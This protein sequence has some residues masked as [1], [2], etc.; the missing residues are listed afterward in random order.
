MNNQR[1]FVYARHLR[2]GV[3]LLLWLLT[4]L[5]AM[6]SGKPAH[7]Q[8]G[9]ICRDEGNITICGD[10]FKDFTFDLGIDGYQ[11]IGNV[12]LGM[13]GKPPVVR[14]SDATGLPAGHKYKRATFEHV[15]DPQKS[16]YSRSN[17]LIG[18]ILF[19]NDPKQRAP[20]GSNGLTVNGNVFAGAF[21]VNTAGEIRSLTADVPAYPA[22]AKNR[23]ALLFNQFYLDHLA[24]RAM[25]AED[26]TVEDRSLF[27]AFYSLDSREFFVFIEIPKLRLFEN[28]ENPALPVEMRIDMDEKGNYAGSATGFKMRMAG[29]TGEAKGIVV[30]PG[31]F[32]ASTLEFSRTDNPSLPNLDPTNPNLVFRLESLKYKDG[33]F[34]VG[35]VVGI[36]DWQLGSAMRLT[37]QSVGLF[38]DNVLKTTSIVISSTLTFPARSVATDGGQ[39]P[40][41]LELGAKQIGGQLITFGKGVLRNANRPALSFGAFSLG[42][43]AATGFVL[44]PQRN[45]Y[46]IEAEQVALTWKGNLGGQTGVETSFK[47]GVNS[48]RALVFSLS[49][50]TIAMPQ[51]RSGALSTQ[52]TGTVN[53]VNDTVTFVLR[54]TARLFLPGNSAVA[55]TAELTIKS[56]KEVCF[57]SCGPTY[58]M[59]LSGFELKVA[60]FALGLKD[61]RGTDDGGFAADVVTLKVPTGI[62][63]FGGQINGFKVT[64]TGD[65]SITGGS[66]ELP[67]LQIGKLSFVGVKG[68]FVKTT[69]GGYEFRGAGVMPLPGLDPSG[70][71]AGK[72]ITVD[73]IV[74]TAPTGDF[75][76]MGVKVLFSTG[77]P[78]IPIGTTGMELLSIS[79]TFDLNAGTVKI[80]V[81]LRAGTSAR[82]GPLPV[83]TINAKADLQ[84]NPFMFTANGELSLLIFK[85]ANAS[86][87]IGHQQ[88]FNGGPG[89]NVSFTINAVIVHGNTFLRVGEVQLSNGSKTTR[90][91]AESRWALG[92]KRS[93]F[94]TLLPPKDL[95]LAAVSFKGGHFRHK[96]GS[97]TLGLKATVGC[98]F[99]FKS[100]VFVDLGNGVDVT[101]GNANDYKLLDAGTVR[102]LAA[103]NASGFQ[104]Q[105]VSASRVMG[106]ELLTAAALTADS[107][108]LQEVIP[109]EIVRR[110]GALFGISYPEGAPILQLQLPDGTMLSEETVD[111]A[112][113]TFIRNTGTLTEPHQVAILLKDVEPGLYTIRVDNAPAQ[114]ETVS[115]VV[116]Q[117]PTLADVT[118]QCGGE[119][120]VG[121]TVNCN[122][123]A[124]GAMATIA[125][126]ATD[127][128]SVDATV[129]VGYSAILTDGVSVDSTNQTLIAE[130]VALGAG[131][132]SWP[133]GEVPTGQYKVVVTV[134]DGQNAAVEMLAETI[135]H[136]TDQRAPAVPSGLQAQ[137]LP[138]ELL[139]TWTPN[140]ELDV[141]GYEIGFGV[142]DP[143]L[144]DDPGRFVYH[145]DMGAKDV[146][147]PTGDLLDAKLWG[148][149]DNQMVF[150]GIR[151]YDRSGNVGDWS[152]LLRAVPWALSPAAW[153]PAPNVT[154]TV[155][156]PIEVAFATAIISETLVSAFDV[157]P[158]DG[159]PVDGLVEV[160]TNLDG[161]QVV[162]LRFTPTAALLD[163]VTYQVTLKGGD[164]GI[165]AA[166]GRRLPVDYT[167]RFTAVAGLGGGST[168]LFLPIIAR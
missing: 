60:G 131:Q 58:A 20:I 105:M 62:N 67:P 152:P 122:G 30:K 8:G 29:M 139:I 95:F 79:G 135:I 83:A 149:T 63:S 114:Y 123:A 154:T 38:V 151:A 82:V 17:I 2:L 112:A 78:G 39:Y 160:L 107:Q 90:I 65:I 93:Q 92:I 19:I 75:S 3:G 159:V 163:G 47:L 127:S 76:G 14:V 116:N 157:R 46:G 143:A 31:E 146:E 40:M 7:A 134:D 74:R 11:L 113:S 155:A 35:G 108:I 140:R 68:S 37:N 150:V 168:Q 148:L 55:P 59:K 10:E 64:G 36:K 43:P 4:A 156:T 21:E 89:F 141:A 167:W 41:R 81:A 98:C 28:S 26:A 13:K 128:D 27:D 9:Q 77:V 94:A 32:E 165:M 25:Y 103:T 73:V 117:A 125:W 110:G 16:P 51:M 144:P 145:R 69:T 86:L 66:F 70:G 45:F 72:K 61:P 106:A 100:S 121:V 120:V 126:T 6:S 44:D 124:A 91:A 22:E 87:G 84:I 101:M 96:S 118:V 23:A 80:G 1:N 130:G 111:N 5:L 142:V 85:V 15:A 50:G 53:N 162:G 102:A 136:V 97:E 33:H 48:Q 147:L 49:G 137:P 138:G 57:K 129:T 109:V 54:G 104:S 52:L 12:T 161:D 115:Y 34:A 88:G 56:G 18:D 158:V 99:F 164:Q 42:L 71:P 166:D 132:A 24:L 119:A 133:L 153:T